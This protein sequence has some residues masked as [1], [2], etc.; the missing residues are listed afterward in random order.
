M[1][2]PSSSYGE[3]VLSHLEKVQELPAEVQAQIAGGVDNY[4]KFARTAKDNALLARI[5]SMAMEEQAKAIGQGANTMDPRW[6]VPAIAEA[7]C[8]AT[9]SLSE[10]YLD[11]LHAKRSSEQLKPS[12][13]ARL[14]C[15]PS[16]L[17]TR[18]LLDFSNRS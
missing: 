16:R 2:S 17:T 8:Y 6:A 11:R 14:V 13:P 3:S 10:G 9:I 12:H 1:S 5:G 4:I 7:W 18:G 15:Q